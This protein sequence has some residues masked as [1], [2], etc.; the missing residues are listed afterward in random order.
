[1]QSQTKLNVQEVPIASSTSS[2][3]TKKSLHFTDIVAPTEQVIV[4][5]TVIQMPAIEILSTKTGAMAAGT[6][7]QTHKAEKHPDALIRKAQK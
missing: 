7:M 3:S 5:D 2:A 6:P 1:M 4:H